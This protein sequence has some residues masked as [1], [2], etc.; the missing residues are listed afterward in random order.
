MGLDE[1]TA[2]A[3]AAWIFGLPLIEIAAIR[4]RGQAA[5]AQM[6]VFTHMQD[7]AD[8]RARMGTTPNNDTLYSFAHVDLSHGPATITLP[9]SGDRYL[10]L[11]LID[12]YTNNF[13]ILGTR[14]TGANG[15]T[16]TLV[17][18]NDAAEEGSIVRSPTR[19]VCAFARTLVA[20]PHD[21]EAAREVMHGVAMWAPAVE[22]LSPMRSARCRLAGVFRQRGAAHG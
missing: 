8:H 6:N 7:L 22:A 14:T 9:S 5:G 10:S 20:G 3:R 11:A 21:L 19:H 13:A 16:F 18:P 1:L 2:S 15:V 4:A 12:A 17:G